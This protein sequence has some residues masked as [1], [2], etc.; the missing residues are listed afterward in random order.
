[1]SQYTVCLEVCNKLHGAVHLM[2]LDI[3]VRQEM[4][5]EAAVHALCIGGEEQGHGSMPTL[6]WMQGGVG[7]FEREDSEVLRKNSETGLTKIAYL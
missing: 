5:Q 7:G 1:M 2:M 4:L 3:K 6:C